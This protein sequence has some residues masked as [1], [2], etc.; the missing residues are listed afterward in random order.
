MV[1]LVFMLDV[2]QPCKWLRKQGCS[3][4][5][6]SEAD[7]GAPLMLANLRCQWSRVHISSRCAR[8][9]PRNTSETGADFAWNLIFKLKPWIEKGGSVWFLLKTRWSF[10][11][12]PSFDLK[13][14]RAPC[15]WL[16]L[17][18]PFMFHLVLFPRPEIWGSNEGHTITKVSLAWNGVQMKTCSAL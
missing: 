4:L 11:V 5:R 7:S 16:A 1:F 9:L 12:Q 13:T 2:I 18:L 17:I 14:E 15:V 8:A 3:S 6:P 10:V